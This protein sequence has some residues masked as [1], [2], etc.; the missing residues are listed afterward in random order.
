MS[1]SRSILHVD[2][3]AFFVAVERVLN[4]RLQGR[5]V[6]VGGAPERRGVVAAASY[7]ARA[8]GVR[9]AMPMGQAMRLCPDL[10]RVGGSHGMYS[11]ASRAV[12]NLLGDYTPIIEKV[13]VDEA[14]LDLSGTDIVVGPAIDAA[15]K[16]RKEVRER[17]RLDL[18]IGMSR[19]RLV[20]K[21]ASAFAKPQGLFDVQPGQE[22]RFLAPLPVEALPGVGPVTA[23]RLHEFNLPKLGGLA[24]TETWFLKDA[25]GN[26][27]PAMQVRARGEDDTP[28][29]P[30]WERRQEKSI[31]HEQT[32]A[33]DTEDHAFLRAKLQELLTRAARRLRAKGLLARKLSIRLRWAD[34]VTV[35]RDV[36]LL[37]ASDHDGELLGPALE[38][39]R[40]MHDR[41][42]LVRLLGV[43][44]SGLVR[45]YWQGTLTDVT[46]TRER[47]LVNALDGIR[48]RHGESAVRCGAV[49]ALKKRHHFSE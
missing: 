1:A 19:N 11:R 32:F 31:G 47:S 4:T 12:F 15:E 39:L 29:C 7:E 30:P 20:S 44:L 16:M 3:D 9:S 33:E 8:F 49:V 43:R 13:S 5:P 14:Y 23:K 24:S 2:L 41:R 45:G 46:A 37:D 48:D 28:V 17:L 10:V 6:V 40:K 36:T 18:T 35:S 21:V 27:G 25:F 22:A 42:T 34:F 26:Y 38:L